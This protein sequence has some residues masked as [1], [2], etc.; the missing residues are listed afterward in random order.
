[1]DIETMTVDVPELSPERIDTF[2][3]VLFLGVFYHLFD[4]IDGLR[5]A[6]T[7]AK[8]VLVVE[9]PYRTQPQGPG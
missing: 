4:P 2:D 9:N 8:Q 5:R 7:L 1:L 6:A 3:I